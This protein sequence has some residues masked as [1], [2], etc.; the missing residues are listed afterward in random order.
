MASKISRDQYKKQQEIEEQRKNGTLPAEVDEEGKDINPHIPE[1]IKS[2]PWYLAYNKPTLKHQRMPEEMKKKT[3]SV[4]EWYERGQKPQATAT[5]YR[6]GACTNCGALTHKRQDCVERPRKLGAKFT[7][8]NIAPDE[9]ALPE[10][11]LD[12]DG[13]HDRWRGYD[14]TQHQ[15]IVEEYEKME[16]EKRRLK[17]EAL[18]EEIRRGPAERVI[19]VGLEDGPPEEDRHDREADVLSDSSRDSDDSDDEKGYADKVETGLLV[20]LVNRT[21]WC[22]KRRRRDAS[23]RGG[24]ASMRGINKEGVQ[25]VKKKQMGKRE[26]LLYAKALR[27]LTYATLFRWINLG[28]S[29]TRN[30]E[31]QYATCAFVRIRP[32]TSGIWTPTR[33]T[34][35]PRHEP[36]APIRTRTRVSTRRSLPTLATTLCG[37]QAK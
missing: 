36:C 11:P 1:Y 18:K 3:A 23:R 35:I 4:H 14:A 9:A 2:A 37:T 19:E 22:Q 32:N 29:W 31:L 17:S 5:R 28:P 33:P 12:F 8:T 20:N 27:W 15:Q 24:E 10:I 21:C 30:G 25:Q 16:A 26:P 7:G 6:K 13:K 34:T